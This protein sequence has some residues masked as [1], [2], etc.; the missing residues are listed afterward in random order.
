MRNRRGEIATIL[1]IG[2]LIVIGV[3]AVISSLGLKDKKTTSSRASCLSTQ[4]TCIGE[5]NTICCDKATKICG[6]DSNDKRICV[7]KP[8]GNSPTPKPPTST[9]ATTNG[10]FPQGECVTECGS[11]NSC[12]KCAGSSKYKCSGSTTNPT[13]IPT[14]AT[15]TPIPSQDTCTK[16]QKFVGNLGYN[17]ETPE[18]ICSAHNGVYVGSNQQGQEND[19]AGKSQR[20]ACCAV[21]DANSVCPKP[22][23]GYACCV[24]DTRECPSGDIRYRWY[25]CTGQVCSATKINTTGG[26]THLFD[27]PLGVNPASPENCSSVLPT[28]KLS[29]DGCEDYGSYGLLGGC[30]EKCTDPSKECKAADGDTVQRFCCPKP[31]PPPETPPTGC[32]ANSGCSASTCPSTTNK[33]VD[34]KWCC[35]KVSIPSTDATTPSSENVES[36]TADTADMGE[37]DILPT[38]EEVVCS[39]GKTGKYAKVKLSTYYVYYN[40]LSE[41]NRYGLNGKKEADVIA[42]ICA[43]LLGPPL[44]ALQLP[45]QLPPLPVGSSATGG[46]L[47]LQ[48]PTDLTVALNQ[49]LSAGVD[50]SSLDLSSTKITFDPNALSFDTD[51][52]VACRPV[53]AGEAAFNFITSEGTKTN[54]CNSNENAGIGGTATAPELVCCKNT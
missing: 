13:S 23:L 45:F 54:P 33:C 20:W 14:T 8:V 47:N 10:C 35:P 49:P 50:W 1:T 22:G 18:Q 15:N 5:T 11:T 51:I 29:I 36:P 46:N 3:T 12:V 41:C 4:L 30:H 21:S 7:T 28:P 25:G 32:T 40:T 52:R 6:W 38:C 9:P 31:L 37:V 42:T 39:G 27:C 43:S 26:F 48:N 17:V 19:T 2:T 24:Q 53:Q 34:G 44:P 16:G